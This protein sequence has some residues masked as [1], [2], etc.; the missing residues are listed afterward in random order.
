MAIWNISNERILL[1]YEQINNVSS[2]ASAI[3]HK[4]FPC[5]FTSPLGLR[6]SF[7]PRQASKSWARQSF[8]L[9]CVNILPI[10]YN[11]TADNNLKEKLTLILIFF[12]DSNDV[13]KIIRLQNEQKKFLLEKHHG[14]L[15]SRE[16]L[17][18]VI[19]TINLNSLCFGNISFKY[20]GR[21]SWQ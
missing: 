6:K 2:D 20:L 16:S 11:E 15:C 10:S 13:K 21:N 14:R 12:L 17:F 18:S 3:T 8:R 7:F 9:G 1:W 5:I 19:P 4:I